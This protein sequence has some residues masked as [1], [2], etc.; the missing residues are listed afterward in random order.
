MDVKELAEYLR[1]TPGHVRDMARGGLIPPYCIIRPLGCRKYRFK[2][3]KIEEWAEM[4]ARR[5]G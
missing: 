3:P 2:R 4:T 1:L 5:R